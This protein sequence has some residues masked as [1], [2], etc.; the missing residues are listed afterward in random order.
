MDFDSREKRWVGGREGCSG[1]VAGMHGEPA[2][3]DWKHGAPC[4]QGTEGGR[5]LIGEWD[6]KSEASILV[7][8]ERG[9]RKGCRDIIESEWREWGVGNVMPQVMF[10]IFGLLQCIYSGSIYTY[11]MYL[12]LFQ[13]K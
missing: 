10:S 4:L 8:M 6:T 5:W 11:C 7:K 12:S 3:G 2:L 1:E 9:R 13:S